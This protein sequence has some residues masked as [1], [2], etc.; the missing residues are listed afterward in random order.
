[1]CKEYPGEFETSIGMTDAVENAIRIAQQWKA[2]CPD[3][4]IMIGIGC[5]HGDTMPFEGMELTEETFA[6]LREKAKKFDESLERCHH[7]G[8]ILGEEKYGCWDLDEFGCC[9]ENCAEQYYATMQEE[10]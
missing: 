2:D 10:E 5:T 6:E 7:C 9:S 1:L 8:D 4:N 3:D